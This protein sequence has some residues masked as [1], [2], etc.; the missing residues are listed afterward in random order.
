M[1]LEVEA[2]VRRRD[3]RLRATLRS[4]SL[5]LAVVGPSGSGKSTLLDVIAGIEP[6]RVV[7]DGEDVTRVPLHRRGV[8]YVQP[9]PGSFPTVAEFHQ[10][11]VQCGALPCAAWLDGTSASEANP[12]ELLR[13]WV[14]QGAVALNIVPE[15]NWNLPDPEMRRLKVDKLYQVVRAAQE[16]DLPLNIGTEMNSFGQKLV[17][18]FGAPELQP[19]KEDFIEGAYF[20]YGHTVMQRHVEL[21][22]Q[23]AWANDQ[24]PTRGRRNEFYA[25]IGRHVPPAPVGSG[26][27]VGVSACMSPSDVLAHVHAYHHR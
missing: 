10:L 20:I 22:Y 1:I 14:G 3:F 6:G 2:D 16:L 12:E 27:L 21:G 7:V 13:F 23:S 26:P 4:E 11:I 8:G 5:R 25:Q 24:L 19:V 17:D 15:R 9:S 18:D